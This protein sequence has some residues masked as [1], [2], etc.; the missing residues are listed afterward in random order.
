[1]KI[2]PIYNKVISVLPS[3]WHYPIKICNSTNHIL[4]AVI[5]RDKLNIRVEDLLG[6]YEQLRDNNLDCEFENLYPSSDKTKRSKT[7]IIGLAGIP[8]LINRYPLEKENVCYIA[9]CLL[10]EI[11]HNIKLPEKYT[12]EKYADKFALKWMKEV[13]KIL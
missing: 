12:T 8:I 7:H 10:H 1:M 4:R 9:C 5:E 13:C 11:G 2:I 6:Y 3:K